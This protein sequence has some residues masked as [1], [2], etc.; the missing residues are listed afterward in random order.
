MLRQK[1]DSQSSRRTNA[2][3]KVKFRRKVPN[4]DEQMEMMC[5]RLDA[6]TQGGLASSLYS[7]MAEGICLHRIIFDENREPADYRILDINQAY[8]DIT[9]IT[10][11]K[12][13]GALAS[14]LYG[15]GKPP[16]LDIYAE[17]A[18]TGKPKK[19]E[20]FFD[21]IGHFAIS[22]VSPEKD[23]FITIFT[24]VTETKASEQILRAQRALAEDLSSTTDYAWALNR[25]LESFIE[26]SG[27]D[28]GGVYVVDASGDL[29]LEMDSGLSD[30]FVGQVGSYS[31]D[32]PQHKLVMLGEPVYSTHPQVVNDVGEEVGE[33]GINALAVIPIKHEGNVIA[34]LNLASHTSDG[35]PDGKTRSV[36]ETMAGYLGSVIARLNAERALADEQKKYCLVEEHLSDVVWT[37]DMNFR[38]TATTKSVERLRGFTSEEVMGHSLAETISPGSIEV[39]ME[40]FKKHLDGANLGRFESVK[41]ELEQPCKDGTTIWTETEMTMVPDNDGKP[42]GI[43]GVTRN[44]DD[45]RET[46]NALKES[47]ERYRIVVEGIQHGIVIANSFPPK[48]LFANSGMLEILGYSIEELQSMPHHELMAIVHPEDVQK[49]FGSYHAGLESGNGMPENYVFRIFR[50]NSEMR[51]IQA[52]ASPSRHK[53]E[54]VLVGFFTDVTEQKEAREAEAIAKQRIETAAHMEALR[55]MAGGIAHDFNNLLTGFYG[56]LDLAIAELEDALLGVSSRTRTKLLSLQAAI[57]ELRPITDRAAA[58]STQL[59]KYSKEVS[60][61]KDEYNPTVFLPSDIF[62]RVFKLLDAGHSSVDKISTSEPDLWPVKA[63]KDAMLDALL[64]LCGNSLDAMPE[65]GR[66]TLAAS[67]YYGAV[68]VLKGEEYANINGRFVRIDVIDTG[69]GMD[70]NTRAKVFD[71]YFTTKEPGKGTGLGVSNAFVFTTDHEGHISCLS[72]TSKDNHGTTFSIFLP[73]TD[74]E[75]T[76]S[77]VPDS[78]SSSVQALKRGTVMLV[79]DEPMIRKIGKASLKRNKCRCILARDGQ[80]AVEIFK[81]RHLEIDLVILDMT[82]PRMGGLEAQRKM[83]EINPDVR[84][85]ISTGYGDSKEAE[86]RA[87]GVLGFLSKPFNLGTFAAALDKYLPEK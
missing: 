15:T 76:S 28:S 86:A 61:R 64:N 87:V 20:V 73:A 3:K 35:G 19:F 6:F 45:R 26:I 18:E 41:L 59:L 38:M 56:N 34:C 31:V 1:T 16:Y 68:P 40:A 43:V 17:V 22:V 62:E 75:I 14:E 69:T 82:M 78:E 37:M 44:I 48:V 66:L 7:G 85:I 80:E 63:D 53:G 29:V 74:E 54:D 42:C 84:T 72:D 11:D 47:E 50:K 57:N 36:I 77:D 33:E 23:Q 60:T 52:S 83:I 2:V 8:S 5:L 67:N 30:S 9:G 65:G 10:R 58:L 79:D 39:A 70:E 55:R 71:P 46:E 27:M 49:I 32:T 24:D 81:E 13:L 4:P 21:H 12:A 51:W 25:A